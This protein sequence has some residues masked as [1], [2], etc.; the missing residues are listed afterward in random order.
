MSLSSHSK[1]V[2]NPRFKSCLLSWNE[3]NLAS[4]SVA[5]VCGSLGAVLTH[6][7]IP[8]LPYLLNYLISG[9]LG[10]GIAWIVC[11]Y[12]FESA[13]SFY[14]PAS[15]W[16]RIYDGISILSAILMLWYL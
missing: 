4:M 9:I 10:F 16:H 7:F 6:S 1:P 15:I 11:E 13:H 12:L 5:I 2:S 14:G 3:I 8:V